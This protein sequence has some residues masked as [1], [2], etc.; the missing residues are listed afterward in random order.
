MLSPHPPPP[1][2]LSNPFK[3]HPIF[4]SHNLHKQVL[5]LEY[6]YDDGSFQPAYIS[7][8]SSPKR[9]FPA[10]LESGQWIYHRHHPSAPTFKYLCTYLIQKVVVLK[11]GF[12]CFLEGEGGVR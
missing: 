6:N 9:S 7:S 11:H 12:F 3:I 8:L 2:G 4:L 5:L 1:N 10:K